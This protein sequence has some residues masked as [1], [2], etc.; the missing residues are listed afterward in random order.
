MTDDYY[1]YSG[2]LSRA[3][4]Q[5]GGLKRKKMKRCYSAVAIFCSG[6]AKTNR[7]FTKPFT[8]TRPRQH[9]SSRAV[10]WT[11][12]R[13][14][15][16]IRGARLCIEKFLEENLFTENQREALGHVI[17]ELHQEWR[18]EWQQHVDEKNR[19]TASGN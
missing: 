4:V 7:W 6:Q 18:Q 1:T 2:L 3:T 13:Q 19:R 16:G 17:A 9:S 5:R 15:R 10:A 8:T 12:R 14:R 11:Q